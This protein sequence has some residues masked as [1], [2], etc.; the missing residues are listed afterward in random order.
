[1]VLNGLNKLGTYT[2]SVTRMPR[3]MY[4]YQDT[5]DIVTPASPT[6]TLGGNHGPLFTYREQES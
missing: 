1:M 3:R 5:F 2:I 4:L 6:A